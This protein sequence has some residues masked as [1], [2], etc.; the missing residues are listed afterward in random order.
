[1]ARKQ[2]TAIAEYSQQLAD[3]AAKISARIAAP[4]GDRIRTRGNST[5]VTPGGEGDTLEVVIVDFLSSNLFYD[6]PF[7]R[8]NP[9]SPACFAINTEPNLLVPSE[10]S[11]SRQ[12][13][14]CRLCPNNQYGS[15]GKGKA[16]K[17]TRLLAVAP[18]ADE[19]EDVPPIWTLS[20]PPTSISAFDAYAKK[21]ASSYKTMPIGVVTT[22]TLDPAVT[23]AAPRFAFTRALSNE[24][25]GKYMALREDA[26]KRL[27]VE[28]DVSQ[29]TPPVAQATG[30]GG[31]IRRTTR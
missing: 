20:I 19:S 3:E 29:Y 11:P 6:R 13:D 9:I 18:I 27:A 8:D 2:T 4:S 31:S 1:M 14:T 15:A 23:H 24:E 12:S 28:P 21:L 17:N 16:C 7:D 26:I 25:L 10:S 5:F 30:R 22:I